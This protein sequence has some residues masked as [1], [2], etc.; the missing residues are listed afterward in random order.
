MRGILF[1]LTFEEW[2]DIW[3]KSRKLSQRGRT[4][5]KYCMSRFGDVGPYSIG[6]VE[7]VTFS[8]NE[9]SKKI[10]DSQRQKISAAMTGRIVSDLTRKRMSIAFTGRKISDAQKAQISK[11]HKGKKLSDEHIRSIVEANT[12]KKRVFTEAWKK[13]MSE[14]AKRRRAREKAN[15]LKP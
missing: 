13:K 8:Q 11:V 7:I 10:S 5:E 9:S 2:L 14:S 1:L 3:V 12:G 4:A 6:N 15:K